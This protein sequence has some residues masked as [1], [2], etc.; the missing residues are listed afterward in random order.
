MFRFEWPTYEVAMPTPEEVRVGDRA[1]RFEAAR[2]SRDWPG[3]G[4]LN[5]DG[6]PLLVCCGV[7]VEQM[8][9][10]RRFALALHRL[11]TMARAKPADVVDMT[12]ALLADDVF[13]SP[14]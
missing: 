14:R 13:R 6:H 9:S 4:Y 11:A 8:A 5:I 7:V 10:A 2:L 1:I 12:G 3:L